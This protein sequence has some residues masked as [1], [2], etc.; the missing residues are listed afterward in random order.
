MTRAIYD[1]NRRVRLTYERE[2]NR[3]DGS[4][5]CS[6]V[7]RTIGNLSEILDIGLN[8]DTIIV[9]RENLWDKSG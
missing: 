7:G 5:A 2:L 3:I 6:M 4:P 8:M 9:Q 1:A